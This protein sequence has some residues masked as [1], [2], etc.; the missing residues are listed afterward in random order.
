MRGLIVKDLLSLL[1]Q[2]KSIIIIILGLIVISFINK[3]YSL[4]AFVVP[5]FLVMTIVTTFSYDEFNKFDSYCNTLPVSRK[6]IVMSKYALVL[7]GNVLSVLV[8]LLVSFIV[9]LI[10]P[11]I[12]LEEFIAMIVG[13]VF[14]INLVI[15]FL[16]PFFYKY[17]VQ[18]GR[19]M[20]F[21]LIILVVT[22]FTIIIKKVNGINAFL[23]NVLNDLNSVS[24]VSFIMIIILFMLF[25][26]YISYRV[27]YYVYKNKEF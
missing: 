8:G 24:V 9:Y 21:A 7:I 2:M 14:G 6:N 19:I 1:R 12:K 20:F 11:S 22:I 10:D 3:D 23:N 16:I 15:S 4:I 25:L 27:S 18:K 17:G 13:G 26:L 5:F